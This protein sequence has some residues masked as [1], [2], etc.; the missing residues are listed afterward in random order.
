MSL[1]PSRAV[2]LDFERLRGRRRR[3]VGDHLAG[4]ARCRARLARLRRIRERAGE[5]TGG[6]PAP[7]AWAAIE[8]RLD[9]GPAVIL[10][11]PPASDGLPASGRGRRATLA[12]AIALV[13][14][15]GVAAA[16]V[17]LTPLG[18]FIASAG[19]PEAPAA[20]PATA[21][22]PVGALEVEV[23]SGGLTVALPDATDAFRLHVVLREVL[24]EE[25]LI[26]LVPLE[27]PGGLSF[28]SGAT[29]V[30]VT[31]AEGGGLEVRAPA[32]G[33]AVRIVARGTVVAVVRDGRVHAPGR[34]A[35]TMLAGSIG[36]LV[37]A[38]GGPGR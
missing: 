20:A 15:A 18:S 29:R 25:A 6:R 19:R 31:G 5:V 16:A 8:A 4:C 37:R 32:T 34:E 21:P 27:A 1:H 7:D 17:V 22:V 30:E 23:P 26:A 2:L 12:A 11:V 36:E 13:G 35:A 10:P 9:E 24:G 33:P 28:R 3:R 38:A 14:F